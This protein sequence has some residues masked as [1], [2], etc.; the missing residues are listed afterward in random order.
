MLTPA[1]DLLTP[2]RGNAPTIFMMGL[3]K[4]GTTVAG[5]ALAAAMGT[6]YEPEAAWDCCQKLGIADCARNEAEFED[7]YNFLP[8]GRFFSKDMRRFFQRCK[9]HTLLGPPIQVGTNDG[10]TEMKRFPIGML[11]ADEMLPDA[12]A[13]A[14]FARAE[15]LNMRLVYVTRHPLTVIRATQSWVAYKQSHGKHLK[16]DTSVPELAKMWRKGARVYTQ[17]PLCESQS[18]F[19]GA[20]STP[21]PPDGPRCVFAAVVRFEDL[22]AAPHGTVVD[23]YTKLFPRSGGHF[24][25]RPPPPRSAAFPAGWHDRVSKAMDTQ[26]NRPDD[27]ERHNYVNE[28]FSDDDLHVVGRDGGHDLMKSLN[29]TMADVYETP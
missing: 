14:N 16:W 12:A 15:R 20:L 3:Q 8:H 13:F 5:A 11:K 18:N 10:G 27:Y 17:A 4:S 2:W 19:P 25:G 29:Y 1:D 24:P 7:T 22:L 26:Q 21:G 9:D 28:S 23:L 6:V